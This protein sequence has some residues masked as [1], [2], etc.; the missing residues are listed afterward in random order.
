M[1]YVQ[2][3][4][5]SDVF[6]ETLAVALQEKGLEVALNRYPHRLQYLPGLLRREPAPRGTDIILGN[7]W[8][9]FAFKR[10]GVPLVAVEHLLVLDP[11]L[12]P[13][14][15]FAQALFHNALIRRFEKSTLRCADCVVA[16]SRYTGKTYEEAL[17]LRPRVIQNGIDTRFFTPEDNAPVG[18]RQRP[19]RLLFVGNMSRRKGA[20]ML[21]QIMQRLGAGYELSYTA[22]IYGK[23]PFPQMAGVRRLGTLD[24]EGVRAEYRRADLLLFPTRLEGLP[25]VAMEAMASGTPVV[26]SDAA[27]LPEVIRSGHNG[28]LCTPNDAVA[29]ADAIANLRDDPDRLMWFAGQAVEDVRRHFS[30]DRMADDYI[31][32]FAELLDAGRKE[33]GD[34]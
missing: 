21:P 14:R 8:N 12:A 30:L 4:S 11:A 16:V 2:G 22:G 1:P 6:T 23:D 13:F 24:H 31:A 32:L 18:A 28:C 10:P 25:L 20:D 27:S 9:A 34:A 26:G 15:T 7:S 5:G 19:F 29:F 17:G 3:D 33:G